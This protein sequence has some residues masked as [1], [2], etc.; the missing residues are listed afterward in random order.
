MIKEKYQWYIS[1]ITIFLS[2]IFVFVMGNFSGVSNISTD[3]NTKTL[4]AVLDKETVT[5]IN[6]DIDK[7]DWQWLLD[8]ASNEEYKSCNVTINGETYYNVGIRPKGNSSLSTVVS[9]DT[10]DR[11]SFKLKFDEYVKGQTYNG[12]ESIVLNNMI[13]DNTYMKEYIS[14]DLYDFMGIAVP[15]MSFSNI[16]VNNEEW[17]F[18]LA[19]EVI[20]E[21]YLEN[22]F[23][24]TEGNLYKPETMAIGENNAKGGRGNPPAMGNGN[25]PNMNGENRDNGMQ[26][27][28]E[29]NNGEQEMGNQ[30]PM[31][32]ENMGQP[33]ADM[34]QQENGKIPGDQANGDKGQMGGG[35]NSNR[36]TEGADFVYIDDEVSSYSIVR[37]SAVFKRTTDSDFKKVINMYKNLNDGTNLEEVLDV[38]EV[39][40]Y[41][42]ANTYLVNLDSYSGAMYHNYYLY[43][44]NGVC[45]IL[46]WDLN[47]SF[48][49]FSG[50]GE[51]GGNSG[52][53]TSTIINF[54]ID[55]PVSGTLENMPLIGKLLE[56]DEYKELYHDYLNEIAD[57]YFNS[58]YYAELVDKLDNLIGDYVKEDPTAFCTYEQYQA[59]IPEMI[60][61]GEDRTNSVLA[62]LNGEQSTTTYGDIES[63]INTS[64]LSSKIGGGK[65]PQSD[66]WNQQAE[67]NVDKNAG[68]SDN[69]ETNN[70]MEQQGKDNNTDKTE[71]QDNQHNMN[72][73]R[74]G[75]PGMEQT[76]SNKKNYLILG[77][78]F[79]A[80]VIGTFGVSRFKRRKI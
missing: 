71:K 53:G 26:N 8:N 56:V 54:P 52:S 25:P 9:S 34:E 36:K 50:M 40:K 69:L 32:G 76:V 51:R 70:P 11:Y 77:G 58:G 6:I 17:G 22:N 67:G 38:E 16:K 80:A 41:F 35:P 45:Q 44:N 18:Y 23:G 65:G 2:V 60:T 30:P 47:L 42:A 12:M 59:S 21:R 5:D 7:S 48:G 57:N 62:Q 79:C 24:T 37:D 29:M 55:N 39:L 64:A 19:I 13:E 63:T 72:E 20:D 27:P 78:L 33:G 68:Q 66:K 74:Q 61:F 28:S 3:G 31:N 49:G 46:P 14:Y 4:D 73:Q 43:E 75:H 15:E 1:M 10:T